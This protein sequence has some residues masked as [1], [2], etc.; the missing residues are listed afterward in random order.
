M[1][2]FSRGK[3]YFLLFMISLLLF[4]WENQVLLMTDPVESNYALTAKEMVTSGNW[5]SPQIFGHFWYDKPIMVYW[6]VALSY[7]VFGIT[8]FAARFPA[9]LC[10]ATSVLLL[11]WYTERITK[12][13]E[14]AIWSAVILA[15][16]LE[17]WVIS[18]AVI[19]DSMLF[20]FTVPTMFSAYIGLTEKNMKHMVIAYGAAA[21]ACLTKGPVGL[22]LP[23]L[24]LLIWCAF[25]RSCKMAL[26]CFPWQGI[27]VFLVVSVPWYAAMYSIHGPDFI[28]MFLGLNN[29]VRATASEHPDQNHFYFYLVILPLS[30][31]PWTG[32]VF[33]EMAARW[34]APDPLYRFLMVWC[35]GT[36]LFYTLMAT[37]YI[38]YVYIA[39]APAAI[40]AAMALPRIADAKDR[41]TRPLLIFPSVFLLIVIAAASMKAPGGD[42]AICYLIIAWAIYKYIR[43]RKSI[44]WHRIARLTA[45]AA[46]AVSVCVIAEGVVPFLHLRSSSDMAQTMH[47]LPREHYFFHTYAVSYTYYTGETAVWL[48]T[49]S[50]PDEA[51]SADSSSRDKRWKGKYILSS[52]P[53][54]VLLKKSGDPAYLYVS[55]GDENAFRS[56]KYRSIFQEYADFPCG[57]IYKMVNEYELLPSNAQS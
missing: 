31:L 17:Y 37:K 14:T 40:L 13:R 8:D 55:H 21:L 47:S 56:W 45:L 11:A 36:V 12:K 52:V 33:R 5:I 10:G 19:T 16:M 3:I 57:K 26:R 38:T 43:Y 41:W 23:G 4:T 32:V 35:W 15:T 51:T 54:T 44:E 29:I 20:L 27:L 34:K 42:W 18:H 50:S 22:V 2:P 53:D 1:K 28:N 9:A 25:M 6:M 7:T 39:L 48:N 49:S 30:L 46:A 24:L